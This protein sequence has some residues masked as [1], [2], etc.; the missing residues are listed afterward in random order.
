MILADKIIYLRKKKGW[1]QEQLAEQLDISRQSVSKWESGTSI[2]DLEKIVKMSKIFAV[3]TD[4]LLKDEIE[5]VDFTYSESEAVG[6]N[7]EQEN[8]RSVS[9]EEANTYMDLVRGSAKN[10]ALGVSLC[11]LSPVCLILLG[12]FVEYGITSMTEERAGGIGMVILLLLVAAGVIIFISDGMKLAKYE[13]L[14][15]ENISLQYGVWG[16][17]EKKKEAFEATYRRC[18]AIGTVICIIGVIPLFAALIITLN[19]AA[20][21][22]C[23]AILLLFV[24]CGVY[25]LTW[26][27][28]IYGSYEKLLQEGDYTKEK[29]EE[30]RSTAFF[31]GVYWC[32][33]VAVYLAISLHNNSWESTWIIWPVAALL[34]VAMKKL[35]GVI[36]RSGKRKK[37]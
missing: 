30:K 10:I 34:F 29:K 19:E 21:V 2:P 5:E 32:I 9:L 12:G 28:S 18:S 4:Y 23:I 11:I 27:G 37:G 33:V 24:A 14:E 36:I 31:P 26:S 13:Y 17:V 16:I 22:C 20:Y 15:T 25:V 1:S 3:S 7:P 6:M 35:I 8:K